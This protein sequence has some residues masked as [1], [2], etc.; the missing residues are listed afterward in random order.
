[1]N[2][3]NKGFF[4]EYQEKIR[5][6]KY[7]IRIPDILELFDIKR[8]KNKEEELENFTDQT[9]NINKRGYLKLPLDELIDYKRMGMKGHD[10]NQSIVKTEQANLQIRVID[11]TTHRSIL[12]E[13]PNKGIIEDRKQ[14]ESYTFKEM[15]QVLARAKLVI[16]YWEW[17]INIDTF[18][19]QFHYPKFSCIACALILFLIATFDPQYV[20]SYLLLIVVVLVA[21]HSPYWAEN[22]Q[23]RF[24]DL[25][26]K[27]VHPLMKDL[28]QIK[29]Q[30]EVQFKKIQE[31]MFENDFQADE[32]LKLKADYNLEEK[33]GL[34]H[35]LREAKK[36]TAHTL[37]VIDLYCD[38]FEK[39][40]NLLK[41]EDPKMTLLFFFVALV[42]LII[43][44]FLPLRLFLMLSFS[45]KFY[46]GRNW[47]K[48]RQMNN[49]E[50]CKIE[51]QNFFDDLKINIENVESPQI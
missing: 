41:W 6:A 40:K 43:V 32:L 51:L 5:L 21:T 22:C 39:Y 44:T 27:D 11:M 16:F 47:N 7:D 33:K 3:K 10:A 2:Q 23:Q 45:Y 28:N 48:K 46:K 35:R 50:I 25:L 1:M 12:V 30:D 19:Y 9:L 31:Q 49:Q 37:N 36:G 29:K 34:M 4:T 8:F 15:N 24:M 26:F 13:N 18:I 14:K 17:F 42:V 20:L 38:Y